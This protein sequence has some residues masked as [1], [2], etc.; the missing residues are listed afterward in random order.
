MRQYSETYHTLETRRKLGDEWSVWQRP[1]ESMFRPSVM[2]AYQGRLVEA[3]E[4]AEKIHIQNCGHMRGVEFRC[5]TKTKT[6]TVATGAID[7]DRFQVHN[8]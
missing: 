1:I 3:I 2:L 4:E 7:E 5:V 6:V 8:S